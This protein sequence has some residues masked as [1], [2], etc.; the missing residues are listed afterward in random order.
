MSM[1]TSFR[2][3][4]RYWWIF[5]VLGT[6]LILFGVLI[7]TFPVAN[8][9]T[10]AIFFETAII[11]NGSLDSGSCSEVS[12]SSVVVLIFRWHGQKPPG[13]PCPASQAFAFHS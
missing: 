9:M 3:V 8:F 12:P 2:Q 5:I 10:L 11:V 13:W 4:I 1:I 7:L 6:A